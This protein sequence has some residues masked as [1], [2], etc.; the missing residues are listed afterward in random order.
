[1]DEGFGFSWLYTSLG[2][3]N[4]RDYLG[5]SNEVFLDPRARPIPEDSTANLLSHMSDL[6]GPPPGR[7]R[8]AVVRESRELRDLADVY[9]DEE[10]LAALRS[11]MSLK[12]AL[13]M[14]VKEEIRLV[15]L[16][17]KASFDLMEANGIAPH[18]KGHEEAV[19][20]ARRCSETAEALVSTLEA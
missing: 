13:R 19:Q 18:Y 16:L 4:V 6:Y 8:E 20:I 9:A 10:A 2:Y 1:M 3:R 7:P 5:I 17:R 11:G 12:E 14:T 15:D